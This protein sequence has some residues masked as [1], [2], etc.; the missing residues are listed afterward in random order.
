MNLTNLEK[1]LL[2]AAKA[3]P[4]G[5]EVPYAFEKRVM[6]HIRSRPGLDSCGVWAQALWRA[7]APCVGIMLLLTAWSLFSPNGGQGTNLAQDFDNTVLAA[8]E[9]EPSAD[10]TW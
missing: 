4:P 7:S 10:S 2:A 6:A 9:P 5:D 1:K 3:N 8:V